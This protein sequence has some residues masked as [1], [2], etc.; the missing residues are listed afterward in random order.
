MHPR[1]LDRLCYR[2]PSS[3]VDAIDEHEPGERLVAVKNVTV[4]EEFFQGHFPGA[5]LMPGVLMIEALAQVATLLLLQ[6]ADGDPAGRAPACA[7]WTTRSSG[8]RSCPAIGVRLEVTLG[9]RGAP[10]A[11]VHGRGLRG[12]ARSWPRPSSCWRS[13]P[14]GAEI[15]PTAIVHPGAEIGDGHVVGPFAVIGPHVR[16]GRDCRIGAS[17][18]IDGWTEIG[19]DNRDLPVRLDRARRRRT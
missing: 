18:V 6:R 12:R 4:N 15:D 10:L 16:I 14:T 17:A 19:D 3:L 9:A 2:Y 8:A 13:S 11:R 1:V 5:P 7:A